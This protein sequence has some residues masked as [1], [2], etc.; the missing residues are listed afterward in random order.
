LF[1][2]TL[3]VQIWVAEHTV[4]QLPQLAAFDVVSMQLEPQSI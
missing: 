3:F 2:H 4:P 1:T